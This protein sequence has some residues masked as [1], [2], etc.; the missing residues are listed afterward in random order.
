[1]VQPEVDL[2]VDRPLT[3]AHTRDRNARDREVQHVL[4]A[5]A[6]P[7]DEE[8]VLAV[9]GDERHEH[10]ARAGTRGERREQAHD[11]PRAGRELRAAREPRVQLAGLHAEA[12]E[13]AARP[14][15]L[16]ASEHVVV[17]VR[18]HRPAHC[19]AQQEQAEIHLVESHGRAQ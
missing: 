15:D 11:E 4:V 5:L 12:F 7:E 14:R 1:M 13:P 18:H 8:A 3:G 16:P 17:T 10:H 2:V 9:V 6:R 19:H